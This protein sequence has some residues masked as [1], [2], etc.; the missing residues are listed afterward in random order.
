[1]IIKR[2]VNENGEIEEVVEYVSD[3]EGGQETQIFDA[4][5]NLISTIVK[6]SS[7][8]V[9]SLGGQKDKISKKGTKTGGVDV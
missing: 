5:G 1:M 9:I 6:Q 2:T 3:A 4:K 7:S 8:K